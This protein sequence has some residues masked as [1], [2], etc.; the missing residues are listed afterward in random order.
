[1]KI[2]L[3]FLMLFNITAYSQERKCAYIPKNSYNFQNKRL[4]SFTQTS[5]L[6]GVI[7]I[8]VVVHVFHNRQNGAIGGANNPNISEEQILSQIE[9]LNEDFRRKLNTNGYNQ[10][11]VGADTEIEFKLANQDPNCEP[12]NGITR[13]YIS[14]AEVD[15]FGQEEF[16]K[17]KSIW[18]PKR[19]FNI[20]VCNLKDDYLG[21]A[22]FP[23]NTGLDGLDDYLS[24][25]TNDGVIIQHS[26]F[27]RKKGTA[28]N[29]KSSYTYGR[30]ATHEVG[31]AL[32]LRHIW[33]DE[34]C[35]NDYCD[36][37]PPQEDSNIFTTCRERFSYCFGS[38]NRE[39]NENYLDYSADICMNIFTLD[40]K[41][42]MR[43]A[44][45]NN[46]F[47]KNEIKSGVLIKPIVSSLPYFYENNQFFESINLGCNKKSVLKVINKEENNYKFIMN[48]GDLVY[49][50]KGAPTLIFNYAASN[51]SENDSVKIY[52]S[53][54]CSSNQ[55]LA[56]V[57][58]GNELFTTTNQEP[59][60]CEQWKSV[61]LRLAN[62]GD[63]NYKIV[64]IEVVK[65]KNSHIY[66]HD[67]KIISPDFIVNQNPS[68]N[69][70]YKNE[71]ENYLKFQTD[72]KNA[73]KLEVLITDIN[74]R[75]VFQNEYQDVSSQ[76]IDIPLPNIGNG[77][78]VLRC[79]QNGK[80]E[81][82]KFVIY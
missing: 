80:V 22:R 12:T 79:M 6:S 53:N 31:H 7:T 36:D 59:F 56:K 4:Q 8:P 44:I 2:F 24:D 28:N 70:V 3:F 32:G 10:N 30:T 26:A 9:V 18:D 13:H 17:A 55:I 68:L 23:D 34:N 14:S 42:R 81:L 5:T 21:A 33:G 57:I 15:V 16:I 78:Y 73:S 65:S 63:E 71:G 60:A 50:K 41:N 69:R 35:G 39:M 20:W 61:S 58:T 38:E 11:P 49:I 27:G 43:L 54:A 45:Q 40:Q 51:I 29:S 76:T 37:T 74:G 52:L 64:K 75:I 19:Y 1:M 82:S 66:F 47:R 46:P 77:I 62:F 48:I 72:A 67:L 25:S